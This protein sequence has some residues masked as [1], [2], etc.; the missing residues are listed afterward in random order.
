HIFMVIMGH[1]FD[2]LAN[3]GIRMLLIFVKL[4]VL[5][6]KRKEVWQII[7]SLAAQIK[8]DVK[9]RYCEGGDNEVN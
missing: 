2:D 5:T 1:E 7:H 6:Q 9:S 8:N 4:D 3:G